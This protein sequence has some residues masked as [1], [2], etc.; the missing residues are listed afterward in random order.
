LHRLGQTVPRQD[1]GGEAANSAAPGS[2]QRWRWM[3]RNQRQMMAR[4]Q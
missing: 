2:R 3:A 1:V 4:I